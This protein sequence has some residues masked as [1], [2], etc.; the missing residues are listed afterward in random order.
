MAI[1]QAKNWGSAKYRVWLLGDIH[2]RE[3]YTTYSTL[4]D[5]GVD[6]E[7]LRSSTSVDQWHHDQMWIGSKKSISA[8]SFIDGSKKKRTHEII[9]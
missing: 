3:K 9:F 6:I 4:G 8:F 2:H 1:E 5:S 7:F